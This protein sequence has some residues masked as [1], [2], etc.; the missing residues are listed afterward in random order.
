M[1]YI[2]LSQ[3]NFAYDIHSLVKAFYPSEEVLISNNIDK[4]RES[5]CKEPDY[6]IELNNDNFQIK[7]GIESDK[8]GIN[9]SG[10]DI[11]NRLEYKNE[12]KRALYNI[13]SGA[14]GISLPWGVLTGIRPT[15]I[16][17]SILDNGL[18]KTDVIDKMTSAYY[19][20]R[21]K[22]SL[23]ADIAEYENEILSKIDYEKGYSLYIGIPFCPSTCLYCSFTSYAIGAYRKW[24][25]DYIAALKKE[26][27]YVSEHFKDRILNT[28]YIGGG[29][30]TTLEA[31]ELRD[32]ID[33]LKSSLDF[34]NVL[35]FTVEA[36]RAD[37]ITEDKLRCLYEAG[38]TRISVNP[39]TMNE[40]TL[41]II[42]RKATAAAT[43]E[44]YKI[45]RDIGFDNINMDL[46]IGLPGEDIEDVRYT[47]EKVR[48]LKPD[49]LTVHSL[50]IKRA[51]RLSQVIDE[52]G[53]D[54]IRNSDEIM[55]LTN[56]VAT[57]MDMKAYYLYRQKNMTGNFENVGYALRNKAGIY[58]ILIMEEVQDIVALGAG[59]VSKRLFPGGRLERCDTVKDVNL[60]IDKIDEMIERKHKLYSVQS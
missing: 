2:L 1:K 14:T 46:I 29:T 21:A 18:S 39:Q 3:D 17:K 51:S 55:E 5:G 33:Y 15:K 41:K 49:S 19:C 53:Y 45:A 34:S 32:L 35:E 38:V 24:V 43:V 13:L 11:N 37:S 30:P 36:G 7:H 8:S 31:D 44:A 4:L 27:D 28:V 56:R 9:A 50:A 16:A 48:E 60:Y 57:D 25:P 40:D 23:A 10:L 54:M 20:S 58:N 52:M 6:F 26:I 22:S 12:L 47:L 59:T 42:G